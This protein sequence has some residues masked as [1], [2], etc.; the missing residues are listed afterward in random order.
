L[1]DYFLRDNL[2]LTLLDFDNF[3]EDLNSLSQV[4]PAHPQL[5][6]HISVPPVRS[7]PLY[8]AMFVC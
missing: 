6:P 8:T 7:M 4:V 2:F 1:K 5:V 3:D